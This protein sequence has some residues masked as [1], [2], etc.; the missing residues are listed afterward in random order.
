MIITMS[1]AVTVEIEM[2]FIEAVG[3][4]K[5]LLGIP[6]EEAEEVGAALQVRLSEI[7]GQ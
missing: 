4:Y 5:I 7:I 6:D 2:D 1:D 3:L